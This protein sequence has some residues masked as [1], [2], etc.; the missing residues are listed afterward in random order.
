MKKG[1]LP[2]LPQ[3]VCFR[4]PDVYMAELVTRAQKQ[5]VSPGEFARQVLIEYLDDEKREQLEAGLGA[6]KAEIGFFR[7]DFATTVEALLV[8]AGAGSVKP[9]EAQN[10]VEERLRQA[11]AGKT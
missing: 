1:T 9:L 8:L 4:L 3:T 7:G 6:L 2:K 11:R 5:R 10:W